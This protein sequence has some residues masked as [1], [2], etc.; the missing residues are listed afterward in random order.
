MFNNCKHIKSKGVWSLVDVGGGLEVT[1][2]GTGFT[3]R[4][5][6]IYNGSN[7]L[8]S[9]INNI[10]NTGIQRIN[11]SYTSDGIIATTYSAYQQ[12]Y[13]DGTNLAFASGTNGPNSITNVIVINPSTYSIIGS[14]L[15]GSGEAI[16]G[17]VKFGSYYFI[18]DRFSDYS[19]T[20]TTP[21]TLTQVKGLANSAKYS[22]SFG[23]NSFD[24]YDAANTR[25]FHSAAEPSS[26]Y[27]PIIVT[28]SGTNCY[29]TY[30][31]RP[32][33]D[34]Y[35]YGGIIV[36]NKA[37][38][39]TSNNYI[40]AYSITDLT[41][42][43]YLVNSVNFG[44]VTG[45]YYDAL[46]KVDNTIIIGSNSTITDYI[47]YLNIDTYTIVRVPKNSVAAR[48]ECWTKAFGGTAHCVARNGN[49]YSIE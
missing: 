22:Y 32:F 1:L 23:G 30:L 4:G 46:S 47:Y 12:I 35:Y 13:Y 15:H 19:Y 26:Y 38:Y 42:E 29:K 41:Y 36:N 5:K 9:G 8:G 24:S 21:A 7:L 43:S 34:V 25:Y 14:E 3:H 16:R 39:I 27:Y 18:Y 10:V 17:I 20:E 2:K 33:N 45:N 40:V 48:F 49:V 11:S 6:Y 37:W 28:A 31:S 44:T